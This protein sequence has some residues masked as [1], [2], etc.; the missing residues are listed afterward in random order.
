MFSVIAVHLCMYLMAGDILYAYWIDLGT[1]FFPEIG[2]LSYGI[3]T[4][5]L[6]LFAAAIVEIVESAALAALSYSHSDTTGEDE[7]TK[8][9]INTHRFDMYFLLSVRFHIIERMRTR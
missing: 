1:G 9:T 4:W 7:L 5:N 6:I 2:N 8:V 3:F